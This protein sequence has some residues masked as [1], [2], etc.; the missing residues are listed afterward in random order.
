MAKNI[1]SIFIKKLSATDKEQWIGMG[2]G[3][4][5]VVAKAPTKSKR[6]V[7]KTKIGCPLKKTVFSKTWSMD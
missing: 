6:F 3:C 2:G 1:T 4:Y 5:L 7:G